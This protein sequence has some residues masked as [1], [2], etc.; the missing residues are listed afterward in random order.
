MN[1]SNNEVAIDVGGGYGEYFVDRA[2]HERNRQFLILEPRNLRLKRVPRNLHVITW[3]SHPELELPLASNSID[4]ANL[5]FLWGEISYKEEDTD[6]AN[7]EAPKRY[8]LLL[9]Q[10]HRV[11]RP[12]GS[13]KI[14]DANGLLSKIKEALRGEMYKIEKIEPLSNTQ[15]SY[16][17]QTHHDT[18]VKR[19]IDFA[20]PMTI[21]AFPTKKL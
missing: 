2:R 1:V 5:N 13:L 8:G 17:S 19:G 3:G 12:S 15:M 10:I 6:D 9:R 16:W 21:L 7:N 14:T 11:L 4:E 18:F 20:K